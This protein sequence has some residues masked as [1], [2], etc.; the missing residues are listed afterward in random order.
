[1]LNSPSP[2]LVY[3][4]NLGSS[5]TR[6]DSEH[7]GLF[8]TAPIDANHNIHTGAFAD[9]V[10]LSFGG[11]EFDPMTGSSQGSSVDVTLAPSDEVLS[12]LNTNRIESKEI[13]VYAARS[14]DGTAIPGGRYAKLFRG[15][16]IDVQF[17][18][19]SLQI[20]GSTIDT[21][22]ESPTQSV[23][24]Q[25]LM[26]TVPVW[27]APAGVYGAKGVT[28]D[29]NQG[30]LTSYS[31]PIE[32][33]LACM[34]AV[35]IPADWYDATSWDSTDAS[36]DT[37][38]HYCCSR[39]WNDSRDNRLVETTPVFDIVRELAYLS[40]GAAIVREDGKIYFTLYDAAASSVF[41]FYDAIDIVED[42][43]LTRRRIADIVTE[44]VV[45]THYVPDSSGS[46]TAAYLAQMIASEAVAA[47]Y[48][49][50][51]Q[52]G[53]ETKNSAFTIADQWF[54][55]YATNNAT[56]D[57]T[58]ATMV[59]D[60]PGHSSSGDI[61][62]VGWVGVDD[63]PT[64]SPV[65]AVDATHRG[66]VLIVDEG[67]DD[68]G[69]YDFQSISYDSDTSQIT[70]GTMSKV[71]GDTITSTAAGNLHC[72][73][74]TAVY[75]LVES[76]LERFS[77]G[78]TVIKLRSTIRSLAVELGDL[79]QLSTTRVYGYGYTGSTGSDKFEVVGKKVVP[80][81]NT[82][83]WKLLRATQHSTS[84]TLYPGTIDRFGAQ[85]IN[86]APEQEWQKTGLASSWTDRYTDFGF[87]AS[88]IDIDGGVP[89]VPASGLALSIGEMLY[90][91]DGA[92]KNIPA[93]IYTFT[94]SRD[95]YVW[96][97][98]SRTTRGR[99]SFSEVA[100]GAA[101]PATPSGT[102]PWLM[103]RADS[104]D[105]TDIVEIGNAG[106]VGTRSVALHERLS[107]WRSEESSNSKTSGMAVPTGA[108]LTQTVTTGVAVVGGKRVEKFVGESHTFTASRHIWVD[109]DD[110]GTLYYTE[111]ALASTETIATTTGRT[112]LGV[113]TTDGSGVTSW[114]PYPLKR[115]MSSR[116]LQT[117]AVRT[118]LIPNGTLDDYDISTR[119]P[120]GW[121]KDQNDGATIQADTD[122][123]SGR[124]V[125]DC[126]LTDVATTSYF[127]SDTF[128][129]APNQRYHMIVI[130]DTDGS[131]FRPDVSVGLQYYN[132]WGA[133]L[134]T[135]Y[136]MLSSSEIIDDSSD[137]GGRLAAVIGGPGSD[138]DQIP[139]TARY[140]RVAVMLEANA[141][142]ASLVSFAEFSLAE[143]PGAG[144][145]VLEGFED[146]SV[147][148]GSPLS[149]GLGSWTDAASAAVD[150]PYLSTV[151]A[152]TVQ[153]RAQGT[154]SWSGDNAGDTIQF[155][156]YDSTNAAAS[157]RQP[158]QTVR[159]TSTAGREGFVSFD[160]IFDVPDG[161]TATMKLQF[162]LAGGSG[163]VYVDD[164]GI[165]AVPLR[166]A[167]DA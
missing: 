166:N 4:V 63:V 58:I 125:I 109:I 106:I 23:A 43:P 144:S 139:A 44:I 124:Y 160:A 50:W 108:S 81:D 129:I 55:G 127:W 142:G 12:L 101:Q 114:F 64:Y 118:G 59:L 16:I 79:V 80:E 86:R 116:A 85:A 15:T 104:S 31:H 164:R 96:L 162:K 40:G 76:L 105:I 156:L 54:G 122:A 143:T 97:A 39:L 3:L 53:T 7:I 13:L 137:E 154:A 70:I 167:D 113:A 62:K 90:T 111:A 74:I 45:K 9:V 5:T 46:G 22:V 24:S 25:R 19:N 27:Y 49:G 89:T 73:D 152:T 36:N 163:T 102:Q 61:A 98:N 32:T 92:I 161:T 41:T 8:Q 34:T 121:G 78:C 67:D 131:S 66:Y 72:Y 28:I 150:V 123:R 10:D 47:G 148:S 146:A 133:S 69:I 126:A 134:G 77:E 136:F 103:V 100:N 107:T 151:A 99:Y 147:A 56:W 88:V 138:D 14:G 157:T 135:R 93:Y 140:A 1:V 115:S 84:V 26:E 165:T 158:I 38:R 20:T 112:R 51:D 119:F 145:V 35:G 52:A 30:Y 75:N 11:Y 94:A 18:N 33:A 37:I 155:R 120:F 130:Y 95:T 65:G 2:D 21:E 87:V 29:G 71:A 91:A 68:A 141:G 82:I 110:D 17:A 128:S 42:M 83:E 57:G 159:N 60:L 132:E 153:V 48:Y 149:D 117:S 6:G